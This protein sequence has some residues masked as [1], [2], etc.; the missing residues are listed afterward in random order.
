MK[1]KKLILP[2]M[3]FICAIGMSFASSNFVAEQSTGYVFRNNTWEQV[4]VSCD[5]QEENACLVKF[6][7]NGQEYQVYDSDLETERPGSGEAILI[8]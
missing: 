2:L 7:E 3:A 4:S 5:T 6:S 1:S 8:D